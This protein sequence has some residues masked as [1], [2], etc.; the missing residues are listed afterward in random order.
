MKKYIVYAVHELESVFIQY[1]YEFDQESELITNLAT[2]L[3]LTN[4]LIDCHERSRE[5]S[6]KYKGYKQV[7]QL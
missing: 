6:K 5:L 2:D 4:N 7:N 1:L 3:F